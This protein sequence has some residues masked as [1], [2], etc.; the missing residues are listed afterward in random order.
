M[1]LLSNLIKYPFVNMQ[2]KE[3][4]VIQYESDEKNFVPPLIKGPS[5]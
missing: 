4:K 2:G 5:M 3:A 1:R